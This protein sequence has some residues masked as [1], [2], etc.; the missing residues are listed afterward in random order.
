MSRS[1]VVLGVVAVLL[2]G[3]P[4][5]VLAQDK[6]VSTPATV[7][8]PPPTQSTKP[9]EPAKRSNIDSGRGTPSE[10]SFVEVEVRPGSNG[11]SVGGRIVATERGA[12]GKARPAPPDTN[13]RS[14][15]AVENDLVTAVL[16]YTN[17]VDKRRTMLTFYGPGANSGR[18]G[19]APV[20]TDV[21]RLGQDFA[22]SR[23]Y[24]STGRWVYVVCQDADGDVVFGD[25]RPVGSSVTLGELFAE[26]LL[27][28][29][30]PVHGFELSPAGKQ[31]VQFPTLFWID[32]DYWNAER[33]TTRSNGNVSLTLTLVPFET[34][35]NPGDGT[36]PVVCDGPGEVWERDL[37]GETF[38]CKHTYR[39]VDGQPFTVTSTVRFR[40]ETETNSNEV[41]GPFPSLERVD[42]VETGAREIQVVETNG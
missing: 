42:S 25:I 23:S 27:E 6:P 22:T 17:R 1:S 8:K 39:S 20:N 40:L 18:P 35:W 2:L 15:P 38:Y 36:D 31:L 41:L 13:C 30:P 26:A 7:S 11:D 19:T 21:G 10:D 24:S 12:D 5:P 32:Q 4:A 34:E 37:K 16:G 14:V 29:D 28:L 9:P 33:S 3:L